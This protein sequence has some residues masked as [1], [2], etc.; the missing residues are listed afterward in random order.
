MPLLPVMVILNV[1]SSKKYIAESMTPWTATELTRFLRCASLVVI[2]ASFIHI[3]EDT[4]AVFKFHVCRYFLYQCEMLIKCVACHAGSVLKRKVN[5]WLLACEYFR[6]SWLFYC[7]QDRQLYV[8]KHFLFYCKPE[9][10]LNSTVN[11]IC[12]QLVLV[13]CGA[14]G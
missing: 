3:F 11:L 7:T 5:V 10:N 9:H 12:C 13:I 14:S 1:V 6:D 4:S 8:I 2:L